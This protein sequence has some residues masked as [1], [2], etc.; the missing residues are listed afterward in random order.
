[1]HEAPIN[2]GSRRKLYYT[3]FYLA[4]QETISVTQ[5]SDLQTFILLF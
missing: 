4:L 5:I 1:M 2:M 3:Q